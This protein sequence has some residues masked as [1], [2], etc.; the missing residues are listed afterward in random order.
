MQRLEELEKEF[1]EVGYTEEAIKAIEVDGTVD[2][3]EIADFINNLESEKSYWG[4]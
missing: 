2:G 4:E 3:T 1:R